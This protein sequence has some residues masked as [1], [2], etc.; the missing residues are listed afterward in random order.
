[1]DAFLTHVHNIL[2]SISQVILSNPNIWI[3]VLAA[4][5]IAFVYTRYLNIKN[6][7]AR[8]DR[9]LKVYLVNGLIAMILYICFNF[10]TPIGPVIAQATLAGAIAILAPAGYFKW[11]RDKARKL[12]K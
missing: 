8:S 5:S 1:M 12:S 3:P 9:E 6:I 7:N 11:Q 4:W 2:G 10:A